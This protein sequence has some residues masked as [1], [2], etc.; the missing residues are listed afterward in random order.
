M[1]AGRVGEPCAGSSISQRDRSCD[2]SP[3]AGDGDCDA[4]PVGFGTTTDDEM[5]VL[6]G[7]YLTK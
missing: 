7:S 4:C 1:R 5:F 6:A 3:G 2:S